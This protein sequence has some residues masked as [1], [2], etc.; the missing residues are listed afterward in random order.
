MNAL[1]LVYTEYSLLI[2]PAAFAL[3]L[4]R[5]GSSIKRPGRLTTSSLLALSLSLALSAWK[6]VTTPYGPLSLV[7]VGVMTLAMIFG[8]VI[9]GFIGSLGPA[10]GTLLNGGG[11]IAVVMVARG[12]EGLITGYVSKNTEGSSGRILGGVLGG[13]A[14]ISV[15]LGFTYLSGDIS[16]VNEVLSTMLAEVSTGIIVGTGL[17]GIIKRKVPWTEDII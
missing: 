5:K 10:L 17:S 11:P 1:Q 15:V 16:R 7:D 3:Y 14:A 13:T 12:L 2:P 9:G 8:P 6:P 4:W